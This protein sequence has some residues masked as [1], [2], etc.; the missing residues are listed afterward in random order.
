MEIA[1]LSVPLIFSRL[2]EMTS[3]LIYFSFIGHFIVNALSIA[4]SAWALSSFLT[5]IGI[6]FFSVLIVKVA[7]SNDFEKDNI[8]QELNISLRY[9]ALFGI[10][11]IAIAISY[12]AL[13]YRLAGNTSLPNIKV[14]VVFSLCLPAIY[15]QLT[16]FNFLSA[17]KKTLPEITY[18]WLFNLCL[19]IAGIALILTNTTTNILNFISIYVIL[20]W[21]FTALAL[22]TLNQNIR[23]CI[24]QFRYFQ[25]I[26]AAAYINYFSSGVPIALCF[27]G[28]SLL[29][30]IY[31]F[32]SKYLGDVSLSAYQL[33]L[34]YVSIVYMISIGVGNGTGIL[35]ARHYAQKNFQ[36]LR[37]DYIQ[38]ITFGIL[39]LAPFLLATYFFREDIA[40]LY[41]SDTATRRLIEKNILISIPF[42]FFEYIYVVT[43]TTLRSMGDHWIPALMT[44]SSLNILGITVSAALLLFYDRS[45]SSIFL[46]LVF[47]SLILMCLLLYRLSYVYRTWTS[48]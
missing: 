19:I 16:I 42:L 43:R 46:T 7:S 23:L 32:I 18:T 6:G 45:V 35:V 12:E 13:T 17:I 15:I 10:T 29:F 2:G 20:K 38:G 33:S 41:T 4:S 11:I 48:H 30:L 14:L 5:V 8:A 31:S 36:Q 47:C 1:R 27:G 22:N 24:P 39:I 26:S 37:L 3:S 28:E 25:N 40:L 34:H 44:L 9:A 21:L